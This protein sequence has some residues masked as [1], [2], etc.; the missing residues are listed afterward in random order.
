MAP[1]GA[2]RVA[3]VIG[4]PVRHSL[5]PVLHNAAFAASELRWVYV[6][7]DVAPGRGAAA[8]SA[9]A[10]LGL[11][12]L[13]V[14]MPHK[15]DVAAAL[16][17]LSPAAAALEAVNCVRWDGDELVGENTDGEGFVRSL[18]LDSGFDPAGASCVVVGAGGAA[19]AV[20]LALAQAGASWLGIVNRTSAKAESLVALVGPRAEVTTL[21]SVPRADLVVNATSVGMGGTSGA[22]ASPI[23]AELLHPDQVVADLIYHP[24]R[25]PLLENA[26]RIGAATVDGLGMLLHQAGLAF[27]LWTGVEPPIDVMRAS[28]LGRLSVRE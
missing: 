22:G 21:E 24:L 8:I 17:R 14:T 19:R 11:G 27:A 4:S 12:G 6:A 26:E 3:G 28:A 18:R 9:M 20:A 13:S 5:S 23:P 16:P 15:S 2:T 7:F 25:T 1:D 10:T